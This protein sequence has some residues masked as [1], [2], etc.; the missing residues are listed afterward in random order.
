M[1]DSTSTAG[2]N[3][4]IK[5][6]SIE[7]TNRCRKRCSWCY[8]S[9][10]PEGE[11]FWRPEVLAVFI[12]D[13]TANGIEAVSFGGGEPLEYPYFWE[14]MDLVREIPIFKSMTT[15]GL[16]IG[17]ETP[18]RLAGTLDKVHI[19]IHDPADVPGAILSVLA[20]SKAGIKAGLN[21]LVKGKNEKAEIK[22]ARQL[23]EAGIKPEEAIFLPLRG[24]K[25][26]VPPDYLK[27]V[28]LEFSPK[29]QST[30]CLLGCKKSGRFTSV[31]W[32]GQAGWCSFT[33]AKT[34]MEEFT[35]QGMMEALRAKEMVTCG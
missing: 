5:L 26:G 9:S 10:N 20:L 30:F 22:A 34:R 7:L 25:S 13:L 16:E 17:P 33:K 6:V 23:R 8:N 15:N 14:L 12:K 21:F 29:F 27:L 11:T 28:A 24:E 2:S 32:Q 31:D 3:G 18:K 4:Q 1:T 35:Y 19:S